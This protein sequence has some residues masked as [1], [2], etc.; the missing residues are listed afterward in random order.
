MIIAKLESFPDDLQPISVALK[1][2][3]TDAE[4]DEGPEHSFCKILNK[5]PKNFRNI[6]TIAK[7][8]ETE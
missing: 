2:K 5:N 3:N 4:T 6:F 7:E 1:F 8:F